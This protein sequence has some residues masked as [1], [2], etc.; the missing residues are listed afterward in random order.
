MLTAYSVIFLLHSKHIMLW[1]LCAERSCCL[2]H[3]LAGINMALANLSFRSGRPYK[4]LST[5]L[6]PSNEV[7]GRLTLPTES[8]KPQ[9]D[10]CRVLLPAKKCL[11]GHDI[12]QIAQS[13]LSI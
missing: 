11:A 5:P 3:P 9:S 2:R 4:A 1:F 10:G 13:L 12:L 6:T 8:G 7:G